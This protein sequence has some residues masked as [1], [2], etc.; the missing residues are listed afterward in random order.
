MSMVSFLTYLNSNLLKF[1]EFSP[2]YR[3]EIKDEMK[4][5]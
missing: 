5:Q 2:E 4:R 3:K 1:P